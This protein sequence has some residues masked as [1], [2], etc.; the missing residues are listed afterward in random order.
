M[1]GAYDFLVSQEMKK[2]LLKKKIFA[3]LR[4]ISNMVR[5]LYSR[6]R[7]WLNLSKHKIQANCKY[8]A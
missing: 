7:A 2:Y 3:P 8:L 4:F 6:T 1:E 5:I